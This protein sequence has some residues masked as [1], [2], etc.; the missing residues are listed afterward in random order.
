MKFSDVDQQLLQEL[1]HQHNVS[2]DK[3]MKLIDVEIEYE[4][5][6]RRAGIYDALRDIIASNHKEADA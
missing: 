5:K 1:C 3:V 2:Y 4:F 6:E